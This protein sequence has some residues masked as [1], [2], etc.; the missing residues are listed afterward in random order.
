MKKLAIII[1][2]IVFWGFKTL[3]AL[4]HG[5][6]QKVF[7]SKPSIS[8]D[9]RT[10]TIKLHVNDVDRGLVLRPVQG[11]TVIP[12]PYSGAIIYVQIANQTTGMYETID[13][14]STD[15]NGNS[16]IHLVLSG[17]HERFR[18][19]KKYS[20]EL[21]N[22]SLNIS[23]FGNRNLAV[24]V[25]DVSGRKILSKFVPP[26]G[27][28]LVSLPKDGLYFMRI[29]DRVIKLSKIGRILLLNE[30]N[31]NL[32]Q[33]T[34]TTKDTVDS[35]TT[36]RLIVTDS[37]GNYGVVDY[38][39]E[40][41]PIPDSIH[42]NVGL[43]NGNQWV[44]NHTVRVQTRTE[45]VQQMWFRFPPGPTRYVGDMLLPWDS[46]TSATP[47]TLKVLYSDS[48]SQQRLWPRDSIVVYRVYRPFRAGTNPTAEDTECINYKIGLNLIGKIEPVHNIFDINQL[49]YKTIALTAE[50]GNYTVTQP[51]WEYYKP[52]RRWIKTAVMVV[53]ADPQGYIDNET[54]IYWECKFA[55]NKE[56]GYDP[57]TFN[58]MNPAPSLTRLDAANLRIGFLW[59]KAYWTGVTDAFLHWCLLDPQTVQ[60]YVNS[61]H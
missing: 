33:H 47:E 1:I 13:T 29:K 9:S 51:Y 7:P 52:Y 27:H 14:T 45:Y 19:Q 35:D 26:D 20:I 22:G 2:F 41:G 23:N 61:G 40:A 48:L 58:F 55:G 56:T 42:V 10:V 3:N 21:L 25:Y 38:P 28:S 18:K 15:S 24:G 43:I 12:V 54:E 37:T 32:D 46:V 17:V 50:D 44:E 31:R 53:V 8:S 5:F 34:L 36:V 30:G 4:P 11:D 49:N 57:S 39:Y 59:A 16:T 6:S 60:H